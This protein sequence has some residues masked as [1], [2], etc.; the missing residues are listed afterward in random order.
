MKPHRL[1]PLALCASS[2]L[3]LSSGCAADSDRPSGPAVEI[4]VAPLTLPGTL[5]VHYALAV[6]NDEPSD[7]TVV[8]DA[9]G[10]VISTNDPIL[11]WQEASVT[12][13]QFGNGPGGDISYIGPCDASLGGDSTNYVALALQQVYVGE[14]NGSQNPVGPFAVSPF[15]QSMSVLDDQ[16]STSDDDADFENP[17]PYDDPCILPF[18][19][20]E[21]ED[22]QVVFN[23]TIMRD[24]DQGFF[25][26]AVNF[27]DIFC[28]AKVDCSYDDAG[29]D[30]IE[31]LFDGDGERAQT[32]VFGL[33]CTQGAGT[34]GTVLHMNGV[35]IECGEDLGKATSP[36]AEPRTCD[37]VKNVYGSV[38]GQV[39]DQST[40]TLPVAFQDTAAAIV[41]PTDDKANGVVIARVHDQHLLGLLGDSVDSDGS[42]DGRTNLRSSANFTDVALWSRVDTTWSVQSVALPLGFTVSSADAAFYDAAGKRLLLNA[43]FA[44]DTDKFATPIAYSLD[45][46]NWILAATPA[47]MQTRDNT[48][49][50]CYVTDLRADRAAGFCQAHPL[51]QTAT[52][53][54]SASKQT[55]GPI[56]LSDRAYASVWDVSTGQRAELAT[57]DLF[58]DPAAQWTA[59]VPSFVSDGSIVGAVFAG[60]ADGG[61][62]KR[63]A[64]WTEDGSGNWGVGPHWGHPHE[65]IAWFEGDV[66]ALGSDGTTSDPAVLARW[67][68]TAWQRWTADK[69]AVPV[70]STVQI[71]GFSPS[72]GYVFGVAAFGSASNQTPFVATLPTSDTSDI[73]VEALPVPDA[74]TGYSFGF[75]GSFVAP[76][77]STLVMAGQDPLDDSIVHVAFRKLSEVWSASVLSEA[78][79]VKTPRTSLAVREPTQ[80]CDLVFGTTIDAATHSKSGVSWDLALASPITPKSYTKPVELLGADDALGTF[81]SY[82]LDPTIVGNAWD[83][84]NDDK[85]VWQYAIYS[86]AED[87]DC[88]GVSCQKVYWNTAVGFDTSVAGCRLIAEATAAPSPGLTDGTT[89][90]FTTWPLISVD[91][92]LTSTP[93][94]DEEDVELLCLQHPLGSPEVRTIYT[95]VHTPQTLCHRFDGTSAQSLANCEWTPYRDRVKETGA[96]AV[97]I[98]QWPRN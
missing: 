57:D 67:N 15:D 32:A 40:R 65:Y 1:V 77:G 58:T 86:G 24:A 4:A 7:P 19:C 44:D 79:A 5:G 43:D 34:T 41:L 52:A 56:A 12:S 64:Q 46:D 84:P 25:D 62:A 20:E 92:P 21:N 48:Y 81:V 91:V 36:I 54:N 10:A 3:A 93:E 76:S 47:V 68:D 31:L 39:A 87:L 2:A 8:F 72:G 53:S 71:L 27:E 16:V 42:L 60:L 98:G 82:E 14:D 63:I 83:P 66:M 18:P 69:L 29:A 80:A 96:I 85:A 97:P 74:L 89:P 51:S 9:T 70:G 73:T 75:A 17:C 37:S 94:S 88:D 45:T 35:R 11:V 33:A 28:S 22:T 61:S 30:P 78:S 50:F 38:T 23:L 59:V 90:E 13:N 95:D 55:A 6:F 26:V 49:A